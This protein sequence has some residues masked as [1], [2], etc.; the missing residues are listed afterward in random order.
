[1]KILPLTLL[2][3]LIA[4]SALADLHA[5][6]DG[7]AATSARPDRAPNLTEKVTLSLKD[8]N[9]KNVLQQLAVLLDVTPIMGADVAGTFSIDAV[10]MPISEIIQRIEAGFKLT[11]RIADGKMLVSKISTESTRPTTDELALDRL[12]LADRSLPRRGT[13]PLPKKDLKTFTLRPEGPGGEVRTVTFASP[14][15][16]ATLPGCREPVGMMLLGSD[17]FDGRSWIAFADLEEVPGGRRLRGRIALAADAKSPEN[18]VP[19]RLPGCGPAFRLLEAG[20]LP[21]KEAAVSPVTVPQTYIVSLQLI[22]VD[23][24]GETVLA[25]PKIASQAS[26]SWVIASGEQIP[27]YGGPKPLEAMAR[28]Q[29]GLLDITDADALLALS[30]SI[31]RDVDPRDGSD[32]V[33]ILIARAA[34]TLRVKFGKPERWTISPTYKL[35]RSALVAEVMLTRPTVMAVPK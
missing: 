4:G 7:S 15:I 26:T 21:I 10:E 5:E 23:E 29:G 31:T 28:F 9:V 35:G 8:A 12:Y 30:V 34:E 19:V 6:K 3:G 24:S 1:M 18:G 16:Q 25:A 17:L 13:G 2:I 32:P 22:E 20:D 27:P 11:I 33:K 14:H